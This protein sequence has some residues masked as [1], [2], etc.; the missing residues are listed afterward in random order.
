M[1]AALHYVRTRLMP[2]T[3]RAATLLGGSLGAAFD[4]AIGHTITRFRH[5][6]H[7]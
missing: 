5:F 4:T 7:H 6:R 2:R 3:Y 1:T